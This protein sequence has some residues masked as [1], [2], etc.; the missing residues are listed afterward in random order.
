VLTLTYA[1]VLPEHRKLLI[2]PDRT[3]CADVDVRFAQ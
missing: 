2:V 1:L 3:V